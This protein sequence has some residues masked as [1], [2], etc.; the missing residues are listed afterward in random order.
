MQQLTLPRVGASVTADTL[1]ALSPEERALSERLVLG[2]L[3]L[4][5]KICKGPSVNDYAPPLPD[6]LGALTSAEARNCRTILG[7]HARDVITA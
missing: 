6:Y 4:G 1:V 5:R 7:D 3:D 2:T